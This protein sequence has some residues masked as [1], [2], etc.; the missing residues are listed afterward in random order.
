MRSGFRKKWDDLQKELNK[1]TKEEKELNSKNKELDTSISELSSKQNDLNDEK[2]FLKTIEDLNNTNDPA[3]IKDYAKKLEEFRQVL[4]KQ[5]AGREE[6]FSDGERLIAGKDPVKVNAAMQ[7]LADQRQ[8][9]G[10][11][12]AFG[13]RRSP[14]DNLQYENTLLN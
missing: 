4:V 10:F 11:T 8:R 6:G 7:T 9:E 13:R 1:L 12:L 3:K 5:L 14:L 2:D